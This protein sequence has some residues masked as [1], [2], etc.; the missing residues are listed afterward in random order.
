MGKTYSTIKDHYKDKAKEYDEIKCQMADKK[1]G[2]GGSKGP[3]KD[4]HKQNKN[5]KKSKE[6]K[7]SKRSK[8]PNM[9]G[10]NKVLDSKQ[11]K[12]VKNTNMYQAQDI[13]F[14]TSQIQPMDKNAAI[15]PGYRKSPELS[16]T[17]ALGKNAFLYAGFSCMQGWKET[18]E[19]VPIGLLALSEDKK[20]SYFAVF[21]GHRGSK[22]SSG[23]GKA[24]HKYICQSQYYK[25]GKYEDAITE[26]FLTCDNDLRNIPALKEHMCGSTACVCIL[27]N[28]C[29]DLY[30][31]NVGDSRII[32]CVDGKAFALSDDHKPFK[33]V[34]KARIEKAGG[35]VANGRVN[36]RLAVARS[37]GDFDYKQDPLLDAKEQLISANPDVISRKV[38]EDWNFIMLGSDGIFDVLTNQEVVDFII[39]GIAEGERPDRISEK[40]MMHCMADFMGQPGGSHDNMTVII[41]CF[42]HGDPYESLVQ[43][44]KEWI[45]NYHDSSYSLSEIG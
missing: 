45:E 7:K 33:P 24:M 5:N 16:K 43:K 40:L 29:E 11:S 3:A 25:A 31:G 26:G 8:N 19:D 2:Q 23:L 14:K 22:V 17:S 21:D 39:S 1:A 10:I 42:L 15:P 35:F 32:C 20:A 6:S 4:H 13:L 27:R 30:V 41:A 18:Q 28:R 37:M 9:E 12:N 34:E 36:G 38:S 44:C